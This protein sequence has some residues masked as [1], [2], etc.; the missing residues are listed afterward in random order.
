[1]KETKERQR[2]REIIFSTIAAKFEKIKSIVPEKGSHPFLTVKVQTLGTFFLKGGFLKKNAWNVIK[3]PFGNTC[4]LHS[5]ISKHQDY[6][7]MNLNPLFPH[8]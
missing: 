6:R 2:Q 5:F 7:L 1:M 4:N 8:A 3:T